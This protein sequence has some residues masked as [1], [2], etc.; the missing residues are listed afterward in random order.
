MAE[1]L[2]AEARALVDRRSPATRGLWPRAAALLGRRAL[3]TA[4]TEHDPRLAGV[5]GRARLPCLRRTLADRAL[6]E[7][8]AL[9]WAA[10]SH[11]THHRDGDLP[12]T[13][14]ELD[15]WFEVVDRLLA[16]TAAAA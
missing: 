15:V 1:Q 6:A 13:S 9:A 3:E 7:D 10:L 8:V 11:A 5:S 4:I 14:A 16:R 2:L 12:P